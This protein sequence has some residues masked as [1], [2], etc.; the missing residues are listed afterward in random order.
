MDALRLNIDKEKNF[1]FCIPVRALAVHHGGSYWRHNGGRGAA[2]VSQREMIKRKIKTRRIRR[3][4]KHKCTR[5][6]T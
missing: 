6:R 5:Q 1:R 4:L 2:P 3:L